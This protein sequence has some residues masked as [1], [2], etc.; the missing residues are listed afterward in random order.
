MSRS[1]RATGRS[2]HVPVVDISRWEMGSARHRAS[3]TAHVDAAAGGTGFVQ[4]LGHGIP[5]PI[6]GGLSQAVDT[7]FAQEA[8]A[9]RA[10]GAPAAW[11]DRGYRSGPD[12]RPG[13]ESFTVGTQ[14]VDHRDL[15][16][17]SARYPEN[18]WPTG[19]P[20]FRHQVMAWFEAARNLARRLTRVFAVT[21]DLPEG[22][23]H[24]Y[25]GHSLDVLRMESAPASGPR[26]DAGILT[27]RWAAPVPGVQI[28]DGGGRWC[29]VAAEPGALLVNVGDLLARWT[30]DRW[31][32]A[33]HRVVPPT[34]GLGAPV[35]HRSAAFFHD[36]DF[37]ALVTTLPTCVDE[38]NP[39]RYAP[40]TVAGYLAERR[41]RDLTGPLGSA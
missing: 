23:F 21:L 15:A 4:I 7:F 32:S 27:I 18:V 13:P 20:R 33:A 12:G 11:I 24:T 22:F 38:R 40:V 34:D 36:G 14:A 35:R 30:N 9:K 28:L 25:T 1:T 17:P 31:V 19:L 6:A 3:I 2:L 26:T 41:G 5:D 8:E 10:V 39:G 16:L 37:D 29:D